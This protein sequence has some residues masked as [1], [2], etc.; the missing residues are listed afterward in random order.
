MVLAEGDDVDTQRRVEV[1]P[2]QVAVRGAEPGRERTGV[3]SPLQL[4]A[5]A[6]LRT[7]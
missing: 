2:V 4:A 3:G 6:A 1:G 5:S 7:K